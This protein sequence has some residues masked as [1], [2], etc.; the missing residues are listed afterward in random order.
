MGGEPTFVS[1]DDR[2]GAEWN[3]EA[4]GP[5][6]RRRAAELLAAAESALRA[7][8]LL[9]FGQGKW[10]P[11]E[12]LPRWSLNA[13]WR[14]DGEPIWSNP[15]LFADERVDYGA[16]EIQALAF[17]AGR[18]ASAWACRPQHIFPAYEDTLYYLWRERRLPSNVDPFDSQPRGRAGARAPAQACFRQGSNKSPGTCCPS[19]ATGSGR[20]RWQTGPWF[21]RDERCT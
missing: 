11:G 5:T 21:L 15:A 12:Q 7:T 16:T 1:V 17:L 20:Q 6:K 10:Y 4:L 19:R 8:G 18:G 3:T 2:D 14:A 13:F 9:H